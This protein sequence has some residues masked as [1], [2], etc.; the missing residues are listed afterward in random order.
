[1]L[2]DVDV[3]GGVCWS[4]MNGVS[5]ERSSFLAQSRAAPFDATVELDALKHNSVDPIRVLRRERAGQR[6]G[7]KVRAAVASRSW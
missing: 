2:C 7:G 4:G 3:V 1:M 5:D 6:N